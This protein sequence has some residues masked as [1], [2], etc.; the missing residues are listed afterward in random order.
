MPPRVAPALALVALAAACGGQRQRL[1]EVHGPE[2]LVEVLPRDAFVEVD[3]VPL[4]PGARTVAI[5]DPRLEHRV[6][7]RAPGFETLEVRVPA[8]LLLGG[9]VG[10]VLRP[11]GFGVGRRLE[12]DE[13]SGLT[14]AAALLLR[15]GLEREAAEYAGR[16]AEV[17]PEAPA[18]RRVLADAMLRL[19]RRNRAVQ[20][21]SA[22]LALAPPEAPDRPEVERRV[23]QLRGD[24]GLPGSAR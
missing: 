23:E 14:S 22:Y 20:E 13:P 7:A 4:G 16:A 10:L 18:P 5:R 11:V 3:G 15:A 1:D 8:S 24:I 6:V 2:G 21:Y 12:L 19:G 17:A 9:R